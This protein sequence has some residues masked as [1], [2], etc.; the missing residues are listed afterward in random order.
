MKS[1]APS[2]RRRRVLACLLTLAMPALAITALAQK[3]DPLSPNE[4]KVTICHN[5]AHNPHTITVAQSAV[6]AHLAHGDTLGPCASEPNVTIC[7]R[8][9]TISVSQS[10]V[11]AHLAHGDSVG[12]CSSFSSSSVSATSARPL[13]APFLP[14]PPTPVLIPPAAPGAVVT[15]EV[16]VCYKGHTVKVTQTSLQTYL[17]IGA[18]LG[19]CKEAGETTATATE[20]ATQPVE[21]KPAAPEK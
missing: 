7:H 20:P 8:G 18:K 12:A 16:E 1:S 10:A 14:P 13:A 11:S 5:V 19:P 3:P 17:S 4:P 2:P 21:E 6:P 15:D 9:R